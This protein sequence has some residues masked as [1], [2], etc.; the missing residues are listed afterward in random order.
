MFVRKKKK[1][2]PKQL[3][4][5]RCGWSDMRKPVVCVDDVEDSIKWR[6]RI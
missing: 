1:R 4:V 2:K 6:C 5:D 3:L